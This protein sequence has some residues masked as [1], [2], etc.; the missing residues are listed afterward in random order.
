STNVLPIYF[1]VSFQICLSHHMEF[2]D[3]F[4]T[5]T[6]V[7]LTANALAVLFVKKDNR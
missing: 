2:N 1:F 6:L 3:D 4:A 7:A 5:Y